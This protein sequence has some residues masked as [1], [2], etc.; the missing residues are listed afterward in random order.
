MFG[1]NKHG[2]DVL[3][4]QF[5]PPKRVDRSS[6]EFTHGEALMFN[7]IRTYIRTNEGARRPIARSVLSRVPQK[8]IDSILFVKA[9][10]EGLECIAKE[11]V[12]SMS[13]LRARL[14]ANSVITTTTDPDAY[15]SRRSEAH[16]EHR[17][18]IE[19]LLR[20]RDARITAA[21][22]ILA[23]NSMAFNSKRSTLSEE[24]AEEIEKVAEQITRE[25]V[26]EMRKCTSRAAIICK[27]I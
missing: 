23:R 7:S 12:E 11:I 17:W 14:L 26:E 6:L 9:V 22:R 10:D 27:S 13:E 4:P 3:A 1:I 19:S 15:L 25:Q 21:S 2:W 18:T 8:D 20:N 24:I 16:I 5:S